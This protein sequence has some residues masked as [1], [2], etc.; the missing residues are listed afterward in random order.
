MQALNRC[1]TPD[2]MGLGQ[3]PS[4][5]AVQGPL[6]SL[7]LHVS[8]LVTGGVIKDS[9]DGS[10]ARSGKDTRFSG[11]LSGFTTAVREN[12]GQKKKKKGDRKEQIRSMTT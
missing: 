3:R 12:S 8:Q 2:D 7:V 1:S 10:D 4:V 6:K 5:M 9:P 11:A